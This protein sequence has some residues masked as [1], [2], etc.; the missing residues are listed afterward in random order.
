MRM[1]ILIYFLIGVI[2]LKL[3][4]TDLEENYLEDYE[5]Y[6][7][8]TLAQHIILYLFL[9]LTWLIFAAIGII[10]GI[11]AELRDNHDDN[12]CIDCLDPS[13]LSDI[14]NTVNDIRK[15]YEK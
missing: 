4:Y 3:I 1:A 14:E 2:V 10:S 13:D 8:L 9:L 6:K 5:D 15:D 7:Q 11:I 12:K